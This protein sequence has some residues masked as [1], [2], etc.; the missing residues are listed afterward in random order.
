M[1]M[2]HTRRLDRLES[3]VAVCPACAPRQV[4]IVDRLR[5]AQ[6]W[7]ADATGGLSELR[8][9]RRICPACGRVARQQITEIH[10]MI[11][12]EVIS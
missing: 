5:T 1:S 9:G 12:A 7:E 2:N 4:T 3:H 10:V 8:P 6:E 11:D